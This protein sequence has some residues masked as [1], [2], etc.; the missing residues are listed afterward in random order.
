MFHH[1]FR[2]G[3]IAFLALNA[4]Q[5]SAQI[6]P[7]QESAYVQTG[8]DR[9]PNFCA[10]FSKYAVTSGD[11]SS[12]NTWSDNV[13]PGPNDRVIV[14]A[15]FT[16]TLHD[17]PVVH[18]ACVHGTLKIGPQSTHLKIVNLL[19]YTDGYLEVGTVDNPIP[20]TNLVEVIF[21]NIPL[22]LA[23][24]PSQFGNGLIVLG[25]IVV[26]GSPRSPTFTRLVGDAAA[27]ATFLDVVDAVNWK[28]D[29]VI[30]LPDSRAYSPA[31]ADFVI[32]Y[33]S[34]MRWERLRV[35]SVDA[36]GRRVS[37]SAPLVFDHPAAHHPNTGQIMEDLTPRIMNLSRNV[38][39]RSEVPT[40]TRGHTMFTGKP[41]VNVRNSEWRDLGR[42]LNYPRVDVTTYDANGNVT[43]LADN[44]QGRYPV[45]FHHCSLQANI[46]DIGTAKGAFVMNSIYNTVDSDL[47]Y[48]PQSLP[49]ANSNDPD[50]NSNRKWAVALHDTSDL[51]FRDN[52][53]YN[54]GGSTVMFETGEEARN[55]VIHNMAARIIGERGRDDEREDH[56]ASHPVDHGYTSTCVWIGNTLNEVADNVCANTWY[57]AYD[58]FTYSGSRTISKFPGADK[59][60]PNS[61]QVVENLQ[62]LPLLMSASSSGDRTWFR[63]NLAFTT[64]LAL[65]D[66]YIGAS[67]ASYFAHHV[68]VSLID[69]HRAF[70][71][72]SSGVHS[73]PNT[74]LHFR[75]F[76]LV[77]DINV[78]RRGYGGR[79]IQQGDYTTVLQRWTRPRIFGVSTG[80]IPTY[81]VSNTTLYSE[82]GFGLE[83]MPMEIIG[84]EMI[85]NTPIELHTR[86]G[87][88]GS[89]T[90]IAPE[91]FIV[92]GMK[93]QTFDDPNRTG[94]FI[95]Y[96]NDG[97]KPNVVSGSSLGGDLV[98]RYNVEVYDH[99]GVN[100][101]NFRIFP[102][103]SA[104][105]ALVPLTNLRR[106]NQYYI[107]CPLPLSNAEAP[108]F[109]GADPAQFTTNQDCFN[110]TLRA[111][112]GR[113]K[114]SNCGTRSD[115]DE[116][117]C[118]FKATG[119]KAP[120]I[121]IDGPIQ[122]P[123][124]STVT[125]TASVVDDGVL[126]NPIQRK[127]A[128]LQGPRKLTLNS[129]TNNQV[130]VTFPAPSDTGAEGW[131]VF[132]HVAW[133][134]ADASDP[135]GELGIQYIRVYVGPNL[136]LKSRG[137][138][139]SPSVSIQYHFLDGSVLP[140]N[141][142]IT[143][144]DILMPVTRISDD[145]L[146][147]PNGVSRGYPTV[148]WRQ[149]SG[150]SQLSMENIETGNPLIKCFAPGTYQLAIDVTDGV[151]SASAGFT[152]TCTG[153]PIATSTP[154][155]TP[156]GSATQTPTP[157][158]TVSGQATA[159]PT[160]PPLQTVSSLPTPGPTAT[161]T[162]RG[163]GTA[164]R[165]P[166]ST[167][168]PENGGT[169]QLRAEVGAFT[170]LAKQL[171]I[172]D[173]IFLPD[174]K[175]AR[176]N[177]SYTVLPSTSSGVGNG[178]SFTKNIGGAN[179]LITG[180]HRSVPGRQLVFG[181]RKAPLLQWKQYDAETGKI[182]RSTASK[183]PLSLFRF[184][185]RKSIPLSNCSN[186][187]VRERLGTKDI[188]SSL[189]RNG[190]VVRFTLPANTYW[191]S[192]TPSWIGSPAFLVLHRANA[193]EKFSIL[194]A[195]GKI[196]ATDSA[197]S[198]SMVAFVEPS[199]KTLPK[200]FVTSVLD[201][202][203]DVQRLYLLTGNNIW[204]NST[205]QGPAAAT[206]VAGRQSESYRWIGSA[207]LD[208]AG[209]PALQVLFTEDGEQS[210]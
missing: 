83:E 55:H 12:P 67:S 187:T 103:E 11:W 210:P 156:P 50:K 79:G 98:Q 202:S 72:F 134:G 162:P 77:N 136:A 137:P 80:I 100:G 2:I 74:R 9:I 159:T 154:T 145:G 60:D 158:P 183:S 70:N 123:L 205:L 207:Y 200:L 29:D 3:I 163:S 39:F 52:T 43:H 139:V 132:S 22:D 86:F 166:P 131:Y 33:N 191:V 44:H 121:I 84:G 133:D 62:A 61:V 82:G 81:K 38:V 109:M 150:P 59:Q 4:S 128:F 40:G 118:P 76:L 48:E 75:D 120:Q 125:F 105:S 195:R 90:G 42:T 24:D 181:V 107:G 129:P 208:A 114:P 73:Y 180:G 192:C 112:G 30:V 119:N 130:S 6:I 189:M 143:V 203:N 99:N 209:N 46:P 113:I 31:D 184:G 13:V 111:Y 126:P 91:K 138:N 186:P 71:I 204:T 144:G 153:A 161:K 78:A 147:G 10:Q 8:Y 45:H 197:E 49:F 53:M 92:R 32:P 106:S 149:V 157:R 17:D 124:G 148:N 58:I 96:V 23:N 95:T 34:R 178:S 122:A 175:G 199:F 110:Q 101:S 93:F 164:S 27:G 176:K 41:F 173:V 174:T 85:A 196:M 18:S 97:P 168:T 135:E 94:R 146:P 117:A 116:F 68:G 198:G 35:T 165:R 206:F 201:S 26:F 172:Q 69:N 63:N 141:P 56:D 87:V 167:Q 170:T 88:V 182:A 188:V 25:K 51:L 152:L 151:L 142:T 65:E 171:K 177:W 89:T 37:L 28:V 57:A 20:S 54:N 127:W 16:V 15:N 140:V 7:P 160:V 19:V 102:Q 179:W 185:S 66:W 1:I 155:S 14:P 194:N 36:G 47:H 21:R 169:S 193:A 104:S 190:T 115:T 64:A 108:D 5:A